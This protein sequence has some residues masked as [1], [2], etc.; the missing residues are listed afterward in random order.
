MLNTVLIGGHALCGGISFVAGAIAIRRGRLFW[1]HWWALVGTMA[2]LA[3]LVA[4]TWGD[5]DPGARLLFSAF[6]V[7]GLFMLTRCW[8]A[9]RVR[10]RPADT[11]PA[12]RYLAHV[13][14]NVIALFD[15]FTVILVLDLGG[16]V[17]LIVAAAVVVAA[18][19][20]RVRRLL[21]RRLLLGPASAP[22]PSPTTPR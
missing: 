21:E 3:V 13:G 6:G 5:L 17:W 7:L 8:L 12:P 4:L 22:R 1:L 11:V 18:V 10:P 19:G 20:H 15:A 14:F 9:S 16:P 2:F